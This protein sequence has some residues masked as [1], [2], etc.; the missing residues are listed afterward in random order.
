MLIR[1]YIYF[2]FNCALL[3]GAWQIR[4]SELKILRSTFISIKM[5]FESK[6][7]DTNNIKCQSINSAQCE[8]LE[9]DNVRK[10]QF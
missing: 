6:A 9:E 1:I 7:E 4:S 5:S 2:Y 3:A 8:N 10:L